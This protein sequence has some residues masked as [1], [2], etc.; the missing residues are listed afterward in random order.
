MYLSVFARAEVTE[1]AADTGEVC[2]REGF[3]L[4]SFFQIFLS[5]S[6]LEGGP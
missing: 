6:R 3:G 4:Q 1:P 2:V 5:P